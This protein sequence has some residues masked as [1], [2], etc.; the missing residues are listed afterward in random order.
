MSAYP[1]F[2]ATVLLMNYCVN[3]F[4]LDQNVYTQMTQEDKQMF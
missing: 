1:S 2:L 4:K 3:L